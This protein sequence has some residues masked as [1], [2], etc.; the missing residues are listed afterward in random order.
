ME[1]NKHK[2]LLNTQMREEDVKKMIRDV[3][4]FPRKGILFKDLTT[5]FKDPDC[6][7]YFEDE[8]YEMY[9]GK[10][11]TKV[12]GIESRGFIMAPILGNRLKVGFVPIRKKGK[13]PADTIEESYSKEYGI[14]TIELHKDALT[15]DD[16]VLLHDDLL[17]TGGTMAAACKLVKKF[18]VKKIYVNFLIE[19]D[20]LEGRKAFDSDIEIHSL[21]HF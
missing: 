20:D 2:P 12:L 11:I 7:K 9:K 4:D 21:L 17:A 8:M 3:L 6:M 13:L 19:L 18:N 14:D 10:G 1:Q 5:A 16:V 15:K